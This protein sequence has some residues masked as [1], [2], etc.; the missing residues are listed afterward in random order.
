MCDAV[1]GRVLDHTVKPQERTETNL[2]LPDSTM[3]LHVVQSTR[4]YG[5][6]PAALAAQEPALGPDAALG[7]GF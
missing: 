6:P 5:P 7:C 2:P 4:H 3:A 1:I